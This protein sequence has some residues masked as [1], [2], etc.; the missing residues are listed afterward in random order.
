MHFFNPHPATSSTT[1]TI[2][3]PAYNIRLPPDATKA[4]ISSIDHIPIAT[5][6]CNQSS[7]QPQTTIARKIPAT[8]SS[9]RGI[10]LS[11]VTATLAFPFTVIWRRVTRSTKSFAQE[12]ND[13]AV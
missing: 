5:D 10:E 8:I 12:F 2:I 7:E 4:T 11:S 3:M 9:I 6:S 13:N 1:V